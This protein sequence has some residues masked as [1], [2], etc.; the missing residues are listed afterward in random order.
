MLSW[1]EGLRKVRA[2]RGGSPVTSYTC[3]PRQ[4]SVSGTT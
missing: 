1:M 4:S 2:E 3:R